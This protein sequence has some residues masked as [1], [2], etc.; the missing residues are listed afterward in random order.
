MA[1]GIQPVDLDPISAG[2][3]Q[4]KIP[5]DKSVDMRFL[6]PGLLKRG[7]IETWNATVERKLPGE[8]IV[9]VA[10]VGN[11]LTHGWGQVDLNASR[12][13]EQAPLSTLYGRTAATY[14]LQG[15]VDSHYNALQVTIDRHFDKGLYIKGAYAWSKAIDLSSDDSWG[16]GLWL[17]PT[18]AGPGYRDRN[19]GMSDFDSRHVFRMSYVWDLPV[20]GSISAAIALDERYS[21]AGSSTGFGAR[22]RDGRPLCMLTRATCGRPA[23]TRPWTR[24]GR[25]RNWAAWGRGRIVTGTTLRRSRL[26]LLSLTRMECSGSTALALLDGTSPYMAQGTPTWTRVCS[27]TSS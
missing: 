15:Y 23:I 27:D 8:F 18:F 17:A 14:Q 5:I 1:G 4:G 11:H 3:S 6:R 13:D 20:V 16:A 7:R 10:Y 26:Y 19:R 21:E 22:L 25:S 2:L 24:S 9:G 12:I